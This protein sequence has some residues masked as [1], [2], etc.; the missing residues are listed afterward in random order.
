MP[1]GSL[2]VF[3]LANPQGNGDFSLTAAGTYT[4][5][6][7]TGFAGIRSMSA[8]VSFA[9]GSGGGS[10]TWY[11]QTSLDQGNTWFD[12]AAGAFTTSSVKTVWN[13]DAEGSVAAGSPTDGSLSAGTA[14]DGVLGD[15]F[16]LKVVTTSTAYVNSTIAAR[17]C[18]R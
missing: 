2:G 13:F 16:R 17:I 4:G 9:Y 18:T 15:R 8:Q 7:A 12:I 5:V 14:L 3:Q 1:V 6:P 11:L 10:G